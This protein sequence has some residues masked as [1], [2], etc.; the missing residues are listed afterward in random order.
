MW[1]VIIIYLIG[2]THIVHNKYIPKQH[3]DWLFND[4]FIPLTPSILV[5]LVTR[6]SFNFAETVSLLQL[7]IIS[8]TI[9]AVSLLSNPITNKNLIVIKYFRNEQSKQL[10]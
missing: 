9:L 7:S 10:T 8:I 4:I 3:F 1:T 6:Y 2:Y 5:I